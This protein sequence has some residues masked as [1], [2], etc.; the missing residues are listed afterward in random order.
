MGT[1]GLTALLLVSIPYFWLASLDLSLEGQVWLGFGTILGLLLMRPFAGDG[2]FRVTFILFTAFTAVRYLI[3]R[4]CYTLPAAG[5]LGF[6]PGLGLYFAEIYSFCVFAVGAFVAVKPVKTKPA[7]LRAD[8]PDLPTVDVL[9]PTYN[10]PLDMVRLT[11]EAACRI[12]WH[13]Q[14]LRIHVLDDGGTT[15]K[16]TSRDPVR[17]REAVE[18]AESLK[19]ICAELGVEYH[20]RERNNHAKAGNINT[21]LAETGGELILILDC[22][23]VPTRDILL[24]TCRPFR[25]DEALFMVQT[26]H[27]FVTA[28]P[29]E[30]NLKTFDTMPGENEMFYGT[31]QQGLD[32]WNATMFCGSAAVLRRRHLAEVGG[33]ALNTVTED[34]ETSMELHSRG[35]RSH[36]IDDVLVAGLSPETFSG[37]VGQRSRWAQGMVQILLLKNPLFKKGLNLGQRLG[38]LSA[39][40]FWMFPFA[41][42]AFILSPLL[43]LLF[44]IEIFDAN[45]VSLMAYVVPH[46]IASMI[47]SNLMYGR[48]RWPLINE[49]YELALAPFLALAVIKTFLNPRKPTF[50][51]TAK[52]ETLS[53]DFISPPGAAVFHRLA[54]VDRRL[55]RRRDPYACRSG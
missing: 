24:R 51:V 44:G 40:L 39:C 54:S 46:I 33:I 50:N 17:R 49:L 10:E 29:L 7:P 27:F 25:N 53:D 41:R 9:I 13:P 23:H 47:Y 4:T 37:F 26:P 21:A 34:A 32:F 30:R 45:A 38:Y 3:W 16:R 28:D 55:D 19:A 43:Y 12:S 36:Y 14:R 2:T 1:V 20:T 5:S 22:D 11:V 31:V 6:V 8:D 42:L 18:R 48:T 15:E 52:G 35:Y